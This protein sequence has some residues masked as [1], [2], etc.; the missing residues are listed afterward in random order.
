MCLMGN[1]NPLEIAV[2]GTPD[3]VK[4][5]TL[6]VLEGA[7]GEGVI[8]SVGGGVSPGMPRENVLA[9][10]EALQEFN[11]KRSSGLR[12]AVHG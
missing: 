4:E 12:E 7:G 1:V 10:L 6:D 5:A 9:M 11:E 8:L 3:E 2:R